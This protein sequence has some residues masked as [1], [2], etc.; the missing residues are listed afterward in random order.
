MM[1]IHGALTDTGI[2]TDVGVIVKLSSRSFR[3]PSLKSEDKISITPFRKYVTETE[4]Y[5]HSCDSESDANLIKM[6]YRQGYISQIWEI[7]CNFVTD[8]I[9]FTTHE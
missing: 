7:I 5:R 4:D 8:I 6:C 9:I 3:R 1:H 2:A